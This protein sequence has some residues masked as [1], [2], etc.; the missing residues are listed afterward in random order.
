MKTIF[1]VISLAVFFQFVHISA[2]TST[3]GNL[4][5]SF[6]PVD[7]TTPN[8][9][10]L[11]NLAVWIQTENDDFVKTRMRFAGALTNDHLPNWSVN[12]GGPANNCLSPDCNV[13]DAITGATKN[14][15][16]STAIEWDGTD[17]LEN[18]VEDGGYKVSLEACW[19]HGDT[20]K[21]FYSYSFVKGPDLTI[22][23]PA[24]NPDYTGV[25]IVWQ[26]SNVGLNDVSDTKINVFPNPVDKGL[27]TFS[28]NKATMVQV[29]NSNGTVLDEYKLDKGQTQ[30]DLDVSNYPAGVYFFKVMDHKK[31]FVEKFVVAH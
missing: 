20:G 2:Q 17:A 1:K 13:V 11:H 7:H 25:V 19:I 26:P 23:T 31:T 27:V 21:C 30:V 18:V 29:L 15:Y 28:L 16:D 12:A 14:D 8:F 24:D 4:L 10:K 6:K 5:F 3:E 22:L 9:G